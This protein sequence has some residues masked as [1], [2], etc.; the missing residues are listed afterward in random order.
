MDYSVNS[1]RMP[2]AQN[3]VGRDIVSPVQ[4]QA[5]TT[6]IVPAIA[7]VADIF[8]KGYAADK[9]AEADA[10]KQSVLGNYARQQA[11]I[12]DGI[13]SGEI[14]PDVAAT[15]S[16]ALFSK[17]LAGYTQFA[18][19]IHKI[20]NSMRSGS[21]LGVAEDAVKAAAETQKAREASAR[22][23]GV[24]LYPWM[25]SATKEIMLQTNEA[26]IRSERE[27]KQSQERASEQ[28]AV[29]ADERTMVDRERKESALKMV[30]DI[31]GNNLNSSSVFIQ[32]LSSKVSQGKVSFEDANV[33]MTQHFAQIEAAIQA[34]SGLS[35]EIASPYR[36]LFS[37]L[38][39]LGSKAI[40]PKTSSETS[41]AMFDEIM[42]K[43][44]LV[45]ITSDPKL[46][47]VVTAN[48]LLGGN[49]VIALGSIK[50]ITDYIARASTVD[51]SQGQGFVPQIVGNP[52][53]E[54]DVLKFLTT[55]IKKVNEGSYSDNPKAEKEAIT[56]VNNILKQTADLQNDPTVKQD[57]AKLADM[58]KFYASPE[59]G[60]FM[61]KGKIN[62]QAA[63]A[64]KQTWQATYDPA[65]QQSIQKRL[66]DWASQSA[67]FSGGGVK[68]VDVA[69]AIDVRY[70]G[71]G[72]EF[73]PK[74][75]KMSLEPYQQKQQE[76]AIA[77]LNAV[78]AGI[79]QSIHIGAHMEGSTDY[80]KYWEE[81]KHLY[82]PQLYPARVG[83]IVNGYKYKGGVYKDPSNWIK[84]E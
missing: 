49:A 17:T 36:S 30:T 39:T 47:A 45:A 4:E 67:A 68:G 59:Y 26:S 41:K 54:K 18:D 51:A 19:D 57:P 42:Y 34:A 27:W 50:P 25:D 75:G 8:M 28:R 22:A 7:N 1:T 2:E 43:S 61:S 9:K 69:E 76:A 35:P 13:A 52:D 37:D 73:I 21:E 10:F 12:N 64:A 46:K 5:M 15:R 63:Q 82:V 53:V 78:K 58:A 74:K 20:N 11:V 33:R 38:K 62:P 81:N 23:N 55:S 72:I 66:N 80:N 77:E 84:V 14:S 83:T 56:S 31:A 44:K 6:N 70:T 24:T 29:S 60:M 79:N 65:V 16:R 71:S 48:S 32:D 3:A 40:D